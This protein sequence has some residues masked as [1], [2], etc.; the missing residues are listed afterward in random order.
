[1]KG[2]EIKI[3]TISQ[4]ERNIPASVK[5]RKEKNSDLINTEY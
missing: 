1:M 5:N 4:S 3:N 2:R